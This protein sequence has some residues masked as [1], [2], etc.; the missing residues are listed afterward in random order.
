M[1]NRTVITQPLLMNVLQTSDNLQRIPSLTD[2]IKMALD[3]FLDDGG[4]V[5]DQTKPDKPK[6]NRL[7][8][9]SYRARMRNL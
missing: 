1:Q 8:P 5:T 6:L 7:T 9:H 4:N 2:V 3:C